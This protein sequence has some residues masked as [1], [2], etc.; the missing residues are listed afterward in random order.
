M[1]N[2]GVAPTFGGIQAF[3][4][5]VDDQADLAADGAAAEQEIADEYESLADSA[6]GIQLAPAA[7]AA[8]VSDIASRIEMNRK[9]NEYYDTKLTALGIFNMSF[10]F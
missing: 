1:A 9:I 6:H 5:G 3:N 2:P 7:H 8:N 4:I 10:K